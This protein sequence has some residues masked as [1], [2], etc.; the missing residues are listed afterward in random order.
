MLRGL[1]YLERFALSDA[2]WTAC[3]P[4]VSYMFFHLATRP[5]DAAVRDRSRAIALRAAARWCREERR[6]PKSVRA[7]DLLWWLAY[8]TYTP[9]KLGLDT[10]SFRRDLAAA[11]KQYDA[12]DFF[13]FDPKRGPP[14]R[15][16]QR[17]RAWQDVLVGA[18]IAEALDLDV[19]CTVPDA[20]GWRPAMQPYPGAERG[21]R[22]NVW[23]A[24]YAVTHLV[25]VLD[26]YSRFRLPLRALAPERELVRAVCRRGIDR[27]DVEIMG[28][29]VDVLL[30]VGDTEN[31]PLVV[32]ARR[33]IL[34]LQNSNGSWGAPG[35]EAYTRMHKTWVALDGLTRYD[36]RELVTP[37]FPRARPAPK[38]RP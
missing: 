9:T 10:R 4:D 35:D 33:R 14:S 8:G 18:H 24:F 3:A 30:A 17:Y 21:L 15:K 20:V 28:E 19:G 25:Y 31:D 5:N 22:W 7:P 26:D 6:V 11:C 1:A 27:G 36:T 13:G 23:C 32:E 16:V 34:A 29:S 37:S 12:V 38:I 2:C